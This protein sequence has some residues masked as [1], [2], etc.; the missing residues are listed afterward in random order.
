MTTNDVLRRLCFALKLSD[1][2]MLEML[3]LA[4]K[5]LDRDMLVTYFKKEEEPGYTLCPDAVLEALLDGMIVKY[6]GKKEDAHGGIPQQLP[7]GTGKAT[8]TTLSP[9][10]GTRSSSTLDNNMILKKLRIALE[11]KEEDLMAIMKLAGVDLSSHELSAL[12]RKKDHKN[13][14][15]CMDQ[16]LRNFLAGLARYDIRKA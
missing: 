5:P 9:S 6:R 7:A 4:D 13:Y 8:A 1:P 10:I 16:F 3:Q 14:K 15:P 12:F 11:L 2:A